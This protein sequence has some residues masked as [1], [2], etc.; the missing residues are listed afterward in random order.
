[1]RTAM[2]VGI[3]VALTS[4]LGVHAYDAKDLEQIAATEAVLEISQ[5]AGLALVDVYVATKS[6]SELA[7]LASS[8]RPGISYAARMALRTLD[9]PVR[10]LLLCDSNELRDRAREA[11]TSEER[12]DAARAYFLAT[13]ASTTIGLLEADAAS[14]EAL[15]WALAAGEMLGGH[16]A[17]YGVLSADQLLNLIAESPHAGIRRAASVALAALWAA[18]GLPLTDVEIEVKLVE[19]TQWQPDLAAAYAGVLAH[20]FLAG[21]ESW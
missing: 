12:L 18:G 11:A 8:T 21:L 7:D 17:A 3:L 19:L 15:E 6:P 5:A 4:G 14:D 1:M 10:S 9:D 16:Y 2:F 20:R 13:R